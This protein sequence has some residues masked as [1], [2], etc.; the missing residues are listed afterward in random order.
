MQSGK[1]IDA[2]PVE[3]GRITYPSG[4]PAGILNYCPGVFLTRIS[5][6]SLSLQLLGKLFIVQAV[7]S[8]ETKNRP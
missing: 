7:K 5:R 8:Q 1:E 2:T 4:R 3:P 6:K